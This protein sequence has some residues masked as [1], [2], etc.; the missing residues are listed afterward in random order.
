MEK[1]IILQYSLKGDFIKEWPSACDVAEYYNVDSGSI[2]AC[3]TGRSR[4]SV[5]FVWKYKYPEKVQKKRRRVQRAR[6]KPCERKPDTGKKISS[7]RKIPVVQY[8]MNCEKVREYSCAEE[9]AIA[10]GCKKRAINRA[11]HKKLCSVK[12]HFWRYIWDTIEK[13]KM[14]IWQQKKNAE[15]KKPRNNKNQISAIMQFTID[16][17]YIKTW[18]FYKE[19]VKAT[20]I[21]N[22]Y[23]ALGNFH[24]SAG[25]FIWV[26]ASDFKEKGMS[27]V[28]AKVEAIKR[29]TMK[30]YLYDKFLEKGKTCQ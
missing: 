7:G 11:C 19:A 3:C 26:K 1:L 18:N 16:G 17:Q 30:K 6:K 25:G 8:D 5:G 29:S 14:M 2:T 15:Y 9:A 28:D 10:V 21:H 22:I 12:K 4:K 20:K 24:H 27:V 23:R 13:E